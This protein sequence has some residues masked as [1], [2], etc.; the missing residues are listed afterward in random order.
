[1]AGSR[2]K[3]TIGWKQL[4]SAALIWSFMTAAVGFWGGTRLSDGWESVRSATSFLPAAWGGRAQEVDYQL[5]EDATRI[6]QENFVRDLPPAY[7]LNSVSIQ[8]VVELVDDPY[9]A[10]LSPEKARLSREANRGRFGGIGARVEWADEHTAVRIVEVFPDQPAH[11]AGLLHGDLV[12]Q[13]D[14]E[15]VSDLG[16]EGTISMVRGEAD[17]DVRLLIRRGAGEFEVLLTRAVIEM[18]VL[19]YQMLGPGGT[20]GHLRFRTFTDG[21]GDKLVAALEQMLDEGMEALI[22]DLRGNSGGFLEEAVQVA[23]AHVGEKLVVTQRGRDGEEGVHVSEQRSML[24]PDMPLAV[25]VDGSSASASELVAGAIQDWERGIVVGIA[26]LGKGSAQTRH[27]LYDGSEVRVT[28]SLWYTPDGR[29]IQDTGIQPDLEV[30]QLPEEAEFGI[31]PPLE[32]ALHHLRSAL[33]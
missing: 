21:S 5:L 25:V 1:M 27:R 30:V 7:E 8:A 14:G 31:D 11:A 6:L 12:V 29:N 26:T 3:W 4:L 22:L 9:T 28:S 24:P 15:D 10:W 20:V 17:S 13:V 23:G 18:D 2:R 19:E 16:M 33:E 32:S